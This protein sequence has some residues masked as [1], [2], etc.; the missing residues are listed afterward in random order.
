MNLNLKKLVLTCIVFN[1][2]FV[3]A[4]CQPT[5][6]EIDAQNAFKNYQHGIELMKK[7]NF[8][9]AIESFND[10]VDLDSSKLNYQY[11][12]G[13]AHYYAKNYSTTITV[14]QNLNKKFAP[15]EDRFY[16]IMGQA[17]IELRKPKKAYKVFLEGLKIFPYSGGL[18][19][20]LGKIELSHKNI[21]LALQYWE[22]GIKA[23]PNY[24]SNYYN[25]AKLYANTDE[26]MWTIIYG[27]IFINLEVSSQ[28]TFEMSKLLYDTYKSC[29]L[30]KSAKNKFVFL[31]NTPV[32]LSE[33]QIKDTMLVHKNLDY[34]YSII[35]RRSLTEFKDEFNTASLIKFRKKF[36]DLW[37]AKNY[38][39]DFNMAILA[40][41]RTLIS[42]EYFEAYNYWLFSKGD[43]KAF[44]DW[45]EINKPVYEK[46][47]KWINENPLD[48]NTLKQIDRITAQQK[49]NDINH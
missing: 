4:Y 8:K 36:V 30:I 44:N 49:A 3:Y 37:Y 38:P 5:A 24:P 10:A 48:M 35:S 19:N 1:L 43:I 27:E 21:N 11:Q 32:Q 9:G 7:N 2:F 34:T 22:N 28:R 42:N 18:N 31:S 33:S 12:L 23:Q 15:G 47:L 45:Y 41:H 14:M 25:A 40:F 26:K 6:A 20:E 46:Y 29:I 16:Q 17:Y 39:A 13:L